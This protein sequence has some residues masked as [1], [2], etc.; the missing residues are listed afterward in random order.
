L[1]VRQ[2]LKNGRLDAGFVT[3]GTVAVFAVLEARQ[4]EPSSGVCLGQVHSPLLLSA[5]SGAA[6]DDDDAAADAAAAALDAIDDAVVSGGDSD[7]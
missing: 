7:W 4:G 5:R 2:K 3:M 1:D 6:A